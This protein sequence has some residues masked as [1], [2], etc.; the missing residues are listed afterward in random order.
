MLLFIIV[1]FLFCMLFIEKGAGLILLL[2]SYSRGN[3]IA[4]ELF[5]IFL[6]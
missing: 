5:D 1:F 2:N 6:L 3:K 4:D